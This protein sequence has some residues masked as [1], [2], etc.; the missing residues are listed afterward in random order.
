MAG[1]GASLALWANVKGT[2]ALPRRR[3]SETAA[4]TL[5]LDKVMSSSLKHSHFYAALRGS[6]EVRLLRER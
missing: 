1:A 5:P 2:Q 4:V 6:N 3:A